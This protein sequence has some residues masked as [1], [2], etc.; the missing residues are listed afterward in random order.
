M[1]HEL[2]VIYN[3]ARK[4]VLRKYKQSQIDKLTVLY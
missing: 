1:E 2:D 4:D 3:T